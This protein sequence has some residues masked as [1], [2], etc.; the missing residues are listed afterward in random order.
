MDK[1]VI[2]KSAAT[3]RG[4]LDVLRK[5]RLRHYYRRAGLRGVSAAVRARAA[6][7]ESLVEINLPRLSASFRVRIPSSDLDV[8]DQIF[9][10]HEYEFDVRFAPRAIVDAGANTGIASIYFANR[11]PSAKILAIEP[12]ESNFRL[13]RHNT[14]PYPNVVPIHAA[15]WHESG[16]INLVDPALGKWGFMTEA[17]NASGAPLGHS[18]VHTV[19]AVTIDQLLETHRLEKIDI[20]KIDIEGAEREVFG[21]SSTW[22]GKVDSVIAELHE[23]LKA[24][25]EKSF[26]QGA[27]GFDDEWLRGE[28]VYR[29]RSSGCMIGPAKRS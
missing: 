12:E 28:N 4:V 25:C 11:F 16:K 9:V 23:R 26:D 7:T 18:F 3:A 20:L 22:I 2:E 15:L 1:S 6:H 13:L 5:M 27:A 14:A 10:H 8:V 21:A 17:G 29:A 19:D 24:G